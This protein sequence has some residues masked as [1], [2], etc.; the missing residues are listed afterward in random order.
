MIYWTARGIRDKQHELIDYLARYQIPL[1][2]INYLIK[3][4]SYHVFHAD[5]EDRQ[6]GGVLV[7]VHYSNKCYAA[8]RPQFTTIEAIGAELKI[9]TQHIA[10]YAILSAR[11]HFNS[12]R[13]G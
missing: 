2:V 1:T 13:H 3:P 10:V 12:C 9:G 8:K 6:R 7:L 11:P 4:Q 5:W